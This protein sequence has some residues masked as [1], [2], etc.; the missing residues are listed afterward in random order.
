MILLWRPMKGHLREEL[1]PPVRHSTSGAARFIFESPLS[2]RVS[3]VVGW[4]HWLWARSLIP[5]RRTGSGQRVEATEVLDIVTTPSVCACGRG[6][7][8]F[9]VRWWFSCAMNAESKRLNVRTARPHQQSLNRLVPHVLLALPGPRREKPRPNWIC[10]PYVLYSG[11]DLQQCTYNMVGLDG[12][13]CSA[14][15]WAARG[16]LVGRSTWASPARCPGFSLGW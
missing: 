7:V 5:Q 15:D 6:R 11:Q 3:D 8:G 4:D 12:P 2:V 9:L 1:F 13:C 14:K 16:P 10:L